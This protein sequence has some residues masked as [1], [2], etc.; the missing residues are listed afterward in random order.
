MGGWAQRVW[1]RIWIQQTERE[2]VCEREKTSISIQTRS[3]HSVG[4]VGGTISFFFFTFTPV[5]LLGAERAEGWQGVTGESRPVGSAQPTA[6]V[7]LSGSAA[8]TQ[9][10]RAVCFHPQ[11]GGV[12]H[13]P[14]CHGSGKL[15]QGEEKTAKVSGR[16]R[17]SHVWWV[18]SCCHNDPE[19][20]LVTHRVQ[21]WQRV[22]SK[23]WHSIWIA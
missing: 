3:K 9:H 6:A 1:A 20:R 18:I 5:V 19:C 4:P 2:R 12:W 21:P 16:H 17:W 10:W 11:H 13:G 14:R 7:W 15:C 8:W 23:Y 22:W